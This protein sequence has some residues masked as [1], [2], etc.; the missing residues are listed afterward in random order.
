ML[1]HKTIEPG[2]LELLKSLM[3]ESEF[4]QLR[5]VG[6]TS[7][8]LQYGHR[9]SID[10]DF[11]GKIQTDDDTI[12]S[13]LHKYGTL[14]VIKESANI[15]VYI[16]NNIKIDIVN[17]NYKWIDAPLSE[18]DIRLATPKDIAAMKVNAIAGRGSKK[19]FIDMYFLLQHYS[20]SD[21]ISFYEEKYPES[22]VF[23]A[24]M[25][26]TYFEDAEEQIMPK[27]FSETSWDTIKEH[28]IKT[29]SKYKLL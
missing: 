4:S 10:L 1:S 3:L 19:D 22:S 8:A 11:F 7:L 21:I 23:R 12:K 28:I 13:I 18:E 24:L 2:T 6:G 17:Y 9:V 14:K 5:L 26:L 29:V 20:L 15:K 16:L 25:S 27:M